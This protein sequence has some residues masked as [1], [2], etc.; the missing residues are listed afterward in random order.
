MGS[1]EAARIGQE[2]M[3]DLASFFDPSRLY[4][5][6]TTTSDI[7]TNR[8][9]TLRTAVRE[10]YGAIAR[11][12]GTCCGPACCSDVVGTNATRLG[13]AEADAN[14]VPEGANL[15]LGC[16]NPLAIASLKSGDVVLDLGSGAGFDCFLASK[17]VGPAGKVIGVDMTPD[18]I[19]KARGNAAR[20][21]YTNVE[22]RLGEIENLPLANESVDVIISNCVINL[23]TDKR[24]V[25]QDAYRVL[26]SG[27]RLAISDIVALKPL[28]AEIAN[29][30]AMFSG[31]MAGATLIEELRRFLTES[32][33]EN[34]TITERPGS[35]E[36]IQEWAPGREIENYVTSA[37]I[38][39]VKPAR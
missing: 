25:V 15:G 21:N 16:G 35:R 31:C 5:C 37:T 7:D 4:L 18:M 23:S 32:G 13:Y 19:S 24:S 30:L 34:V 26:K 28:P 14:S 33:F 6:M 9:E 10:S 36:F 8:K 22:F 1:A 39:A 3:A 20:G 2:R 29:D 17:A 27:G 11:N 38:E 12:N